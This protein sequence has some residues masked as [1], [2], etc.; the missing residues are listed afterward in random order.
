MVIPKIIHQVWEGRTEPSTPIRLQLLAE[1][2]KE[3]NPEWE[4]RLWNGDEMDNLVL[5]HFPEFWSTYRSYPHNVQ[6]WDAIRYMILYVYGGVYTDLDTECFKPIDSL[7]E[8]KTFCFGEEPKEHNF[9]PDL[10]CLVGN[11]FMASSQKQKGWLV[12][13]KELQ[14]AIKQE[15]PVLTVL[16]TTGPLMISRIY[17]TLRD[18]YGSV[19]LPAE[20]TAPIIKSDVQNYILGKD[21]D[22]FESKTASAY[23]AHY[24]FGSWNNNFSFYR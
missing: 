23:C 20:L 11:A 16:N 12:V 2:W 1:T 19:A 24:Y 3:Q 21:C 17:N 22:L 14:E 10:K 5:S 15:Y 13:M 8:N 7:L 6:R 18:V 9:Y 4:Y